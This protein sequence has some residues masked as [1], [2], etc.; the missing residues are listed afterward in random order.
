MPIENQPSELSRASIQGLTRAYAPPS[1]PPLT[2]AKNWK[3]FTFYHASKD[4]SEDITAVS[5]LA[6]IRAP[7][8]AWYKAEVTASV[9]IRTTRDE[10]VR[11]LEC[12]W[13]LGFL[14]P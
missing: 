11:R 7:I 8:A 10:R 4:T 5:A 12:L 1:T 2:A 14:K 6:L 9:E 3:T 13:R